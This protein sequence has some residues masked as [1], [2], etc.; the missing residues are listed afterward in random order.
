MYDIAENKGIKIDENRLSELLGNI[1]VIKISAVNGD[2]C[3]TLITKLKEMSINQG[4]IA[5]QGNLKKDE[6][7]WN[8]RSLTWRGRFF[9]CK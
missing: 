9:I 7:Y 2:G 3:D 1:P 6:F 5:K 4:R 8:D